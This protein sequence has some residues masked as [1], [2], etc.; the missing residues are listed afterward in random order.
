MAVFHEATGPGAAEFWPLIS[1]PQIDLTWRH[2][3]VVGAHRA[4]VVPMAYRV[5]NGDIGDLDR[6]VTYDDIEMTSLGVQPFNN[7]GD[8]WLELF[9]VLEAPSGGRIRAVLAGEFLAPRWL[10]ATSLSYTGVDDFGAVTTTYGTGTALTAAATPPAAGMAVQAFGTK[11]GLKAYTQR[12]RYLNNTGIGLLAGDVDGDGTAKSFAATRADTGP[13]A[14]ITVA[15][16]P[17]DLVASAKPLVVEP[18][19]S[20]KARRLPRPGIPRRVV[21]DIKPEA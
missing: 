4:L 8:S 3:K 12:Q 10:R 20:A 19:L 18:R 16:T 17:A 7:T 2:P 11:T 5:R 15:L 13:W 21:F 14:N 6:T 1:V 9:G